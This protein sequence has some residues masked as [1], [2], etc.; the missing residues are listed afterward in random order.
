[1]RKIVAIVLLLPLGAGGD[2]KERDLAECR[3]EAI[4][5]YPNWRTNNLALALDM[6][7]FTFL[8]MKSKGYVS[9][10]ATPGPCGGWEGALEENCYRKKGLWE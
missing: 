7:D 9:N 3:T 10:Y 5:V 4:K 1:M 8:C 2:S 6:G